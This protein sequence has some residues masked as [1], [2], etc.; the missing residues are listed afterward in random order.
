[1]R[2][3]TQRVTAQSI[4]D[5]QSS[6]MT[7]SDPP[8]IQASFEEMLDVVTRLIQSH[9][10]TRSQSDHRSRFES[11]AAIVIDFAIGSIEGRAGLGFC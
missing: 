11:K 7:I 9:S 5:G 6:T 10:P 8:S 4:I 3:S 2:H 1:M